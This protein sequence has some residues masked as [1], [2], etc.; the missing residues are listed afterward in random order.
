MQSLQTLLEREEDERDQ[1]LKRLQQAEEAARRA[2]AQA[3]MLHGYH[4]EYCQR[5]SAQFARGGSMPVM[6]CYQ[7]FMQRLQQ[8]IAQQQRDAEQ[9]ERRAEQCRAQLAAQQLRVAS[10]RKLIE[11]RQHEL[12]RVAARREQKLGDEIAARTV[13]SSA[14]WPAAGALTNAA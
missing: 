7:G 8:A 9:A 6:Q 3:E 12:Q 2:R 14:A 13:R 4:D 11:R 1:A 5:W 10:V